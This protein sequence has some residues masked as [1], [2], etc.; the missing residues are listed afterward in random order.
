MLVERIAATMSRKRDLSRA[1]DGG[2]HRGLRWAHN[3]RG[4]AGTNG[5]GGHSWSSE[6]RGQ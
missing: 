5:S 6:Q 4:D 2:Q 3:D 1:R